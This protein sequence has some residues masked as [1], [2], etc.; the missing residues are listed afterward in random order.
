MEQNFRFTADGAG[1]SFSQL[2]EFLK[3]HLLEDVMPFWMRHARDEAGGINTCL[4]DDGTLIS[5]EKWLW[6]QWRAVWVFSRLYNQVEK[7]AEWLETALHI[8]RFAA[9]HGWDDTTGGWRLLI[10][11]EGRALRGCDSL[12]VDGFAIY[13]LTELA[14]ATGDAEVVALARKTADHVLRQLAEPHDRIPHFPYPVPPGA[15]VHGLPMMFSLTFWE[16]GQ[17]L[18]EDAYRDAAA[19]MSDEIFQ[20]FYQPDLDL[21]V[22]RIAAGG[23]PFPPPLGTAV[24][25][26]HV[27]EDMWFQ[28]HIARDQGRTARVKEAVRLMRRHAEVGWDAEYGGFFLAVDAHGKPDV[29]WDFPDAK[30]WWPHTEALSAFLLAYDQSGEPWCLDWYRRT[31][32]YSFATFPDARHGEWKQKLTRE[33]KPLTDTVA[34]PVKDPFHLPR[35]LLLCLDVLERLQTPQT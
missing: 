18:D 4:E 3:R 15:R 23:G 22:E 6:S 17:L 28:I 14:R 25:P 1:S 11:H 19:G 31:H 24:V 30:L 9:R 12:Y 26:G 35:A 2:R 10:D 27:I 8:Y 33:G 13:G 29:G 32:D 16:L 5:R 34:L 20:R 7:R 21:I